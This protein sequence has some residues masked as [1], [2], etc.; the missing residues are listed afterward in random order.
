M[1]QFKALVEALEPSTVN[2]W[3]HRHPSLVWLFFQKEAQDALISVMPGQNGR[4]TTIYVH[5]MQI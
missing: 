4:Q 2:G 3:L 5:L 1:A